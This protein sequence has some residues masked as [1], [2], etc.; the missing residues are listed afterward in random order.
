MVRDDVARGRQAYDEGAWDTCRD[1]LRE[2]DGRGELEPDDLRRLAIAEYLT[3]DDESSHAT[4]A[5]V[6]RGF[7]ERGDLR[8]A[9]RSA[10]WS[11]FMLI[12]SGDLAKGS[13][14]IGRA[15]SLSEEHGLDGA[16]AALPRVMEVRVLIDQG[17]LDDAR[18]LARETAAV[19]RRE[20]DPDLEVLSL[21]SVGQT[22]VMQGRVAE[23][24]TCTDITRRRLRWRSRRE[25]ARWRSVGSGPTK[26][27]PSVVSK[28]SEP[29]SSAGDR[30]R[31]TSG[32]ETL[33]GARSST[34]E[35]LRLPSYALRVRGGAGA[36]GRS[37]R[38]TYAG[39]AERP[40]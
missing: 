30:P 3:G 24:L 13:G 12:G 16:E 28:P 19:G 34:T 33:A 36:S 35:E 27:G 37:D 20:G 17:R 1:V 18:A 10:F 2:A 29:R 26:E 32:F 11:G 31:V 39:P 25:R 21:L 4:I 23:A 14:W 5:R 9:V 40:A 38:L 7:L 15:R 22:L 8:L 6:H